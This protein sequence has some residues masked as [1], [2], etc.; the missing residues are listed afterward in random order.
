MNRKRFF[1]LM[2]L[3]PAFFGLAGS[4]MV[5]A[6]QQKTNP[7]DPVI[8]W[9]PLSD[10]LLLTTM[11]GPRASKY[12]DSRITVL[13][14]DPAR[15]TFRLVAAAEQDTVQRTPKEW[16]EREGLLGAINAGMYS[17]TDH[18]SAS[19][20]MRNFTHI[21]NPRFKPGFNALLAFNP[22]DSTLPPLRI[23]DMQNENWK[24]LLDQYQSCFQSIR[25]IDNLG[26]PVY[27]KSRPVQYCSM[28]LLA[29]DQE[30]QVLFLF[31]RSPYSANEMIDFMLKSP[32]H[33][34]SAMYLE[35]GPEASL[36]AKTDSVEVIR[37][38]SFVS[39]TWARDDNETFRTMPNIL[40]FSKK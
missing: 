11:D 30:G 12:G 15:Y 35:G 23:I 20:Y 18:L 2:V 19:G 3:A 10:G 31:T 13:R 21:N 27:W 39:G 1:L 7:A 36:Y 32:L 40:G 38:G 26:H 6:H 8:A 33:V 16:C 17:L 29:V 14:I 28:T 37:I 34:A 25:M 22:A 5:S 4:L 24:P 9:E